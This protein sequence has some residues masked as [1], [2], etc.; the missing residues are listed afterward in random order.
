MRR[1]SLLAA[2]IGI[3][4]V[5]AVPAGSR[6]A[7]DLS[8]NWSGYLEQG[9]PYNVTTATFNVPNLTAAPETRLTSEWVGIDGTDPQDRSLIQAGVTEIYD[10]TTNLVHFHAWWEILPAVERVVPLPV[11]AGDR[12]SVAIARVTGGRW[13]IAIDNLTRHRQFATTQDYSGPGRTADWIVEA[14]SDVHGH[15]D[16]LGH[17]VP[18]V[19]FSG[20]HLGGH[21]GTLRPQTMVQG[22]AIVSTV[23]KL[24]RTSFTVSY[25]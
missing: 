20:V 21:R 23:S 7:V 17:Y 19:T 6:P 1:L 9:G 5:L 4:L 8:H 16:T 14:P 22:G 11:G 3:A 25:R 10:R 12:V 13:R 24:G 2:A 18:D 15:I